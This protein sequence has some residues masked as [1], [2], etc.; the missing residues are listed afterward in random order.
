[1]IMNHDAHAPLMQSYAILS[2]YFQLP[3]FPSS[4]QNNNTNFRSNTTLNQ[5]M[6]ILKAKNT[7]L[8][9]IPPLP[10]LVYVTVSAIEYVTETLCE[11]FA[12][13]SYEEKLA[14]C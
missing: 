7:L 8:T 2:F 11:A 4:I 3:T 13:I 12:C 1:M 6:A 5:I 10:R 9:D 14:M